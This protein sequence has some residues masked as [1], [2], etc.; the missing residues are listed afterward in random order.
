MMDRDN[1][2][3]NTESDTSNR[4]IHHSSERRTLL[5]S[6][7]LSSNVNDAAN[8]Y[9]VFQ[10]LSVHTPTLSPSTTAAVHPLIVPLE[11]EKVDLLLSTAVHLLLNQ[12][13]H[14]R[15]CC[16][17]A[18]LCPPPSCEQPSHP[19]K[20]YWHR[21]RLTMAAAAPKGDVQTACKQAIDLW[22]RQTV[23]CTAM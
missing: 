13:S 1:R 23:V 6:S 17:F 20:S 5:P 9:T 19:H 11:L 3:T 15:T 21:A 2:T 14:A 7:V 10:S 8:G 12:A 18:S 16:L 22:V 4:L